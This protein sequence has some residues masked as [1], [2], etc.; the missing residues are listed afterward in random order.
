M[1]KVF[2]KTDLIKGFLDRSITEGRSP[3]YKGKFQMIVKD[4][5]LYS[6]DESYELARV[7]EDGKKIFVSDLFKNYSTSQQYHRLMR[8]LKGMNYKVF[9]IYGI[10]KDHEEYFARNEDAF[11]LAI[12]KYSRAK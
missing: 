4:K 8:E 6:E 10:P 12:K 11:R 2:N 1:K 3:K 9:K 5:S 7:I